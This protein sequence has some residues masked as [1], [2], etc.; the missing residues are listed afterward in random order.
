MRGANVIQFLLIH[1]ANVYFYSA[2]VKRALMASA[3]KTLIPRIVTEGSEIRSAATQ[4][5]GHGFSTQLSKKFI[6]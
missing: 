1:R 5:F 6:G 3:A 2:L 4:S